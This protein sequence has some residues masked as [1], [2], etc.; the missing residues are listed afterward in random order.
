[1]RISLIEKLSTDR[2]ILSDI[3]PAENIVG[4]FS[5]FF[6]GL[7]RAT[8]LV[9]LILS[10]LTLISCWAASAKGGVNRRGQVGLRK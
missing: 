2:L 9:L 8:V 7:L 5:G 3:N 4:A 1:L 10:L 6:V